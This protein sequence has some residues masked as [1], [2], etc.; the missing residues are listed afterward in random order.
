[1]IKKL[2]KIERKMGLK[3]YREVF[4]TTS[5]D[6]SCENFNFEGIE[7]L[8]LTKKSRTKLYYAHPYCAW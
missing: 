4:K 6:N 7:R 2:D 8:V 5:Y 1:M 3:E